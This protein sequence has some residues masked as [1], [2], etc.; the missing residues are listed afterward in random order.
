[1][2]ANNNNNVTAAETNDA[3]SETANDSLSDDKN[4]TTTE[5]NLT[6]GK[7]KVLITYF[8]NTGNTK[9]IAET[10]AA[11]LD[12]SYIVTIFESQAEVPY[13]SADLNY[14]DDNSRANKEQNDG[15]IRPEVAGTLEN[16]N[17]YDVIL[18]GYPIWWGKAPRIM[19]TFLETYDFSDRKI[20]PFCTSGGS[21]ITGSIP[22]IRDAA[23]QSTILEGRRFTAD[24]SA[25]EVGS[26][27]KSIMN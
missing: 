6:D 23:P 4:T 21:S 9:G 3:N 7:T 22:E 13:T 17:K 25:D 18:V 8:S 19:L 5:G 2:A 11:E 14:N 16:A 12:D 15:K 10:A 1:M 24:A 20:A 27:F 26:W